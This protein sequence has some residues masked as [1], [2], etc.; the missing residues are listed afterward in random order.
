[1]IFLPENSHSRRIVDAVSWKIRRK[2]RVEQ[3]FSILLK[4]L[5]LLPNLANPG[6]AT[7]DSGWKFDWSRNCVPEDG[8][9][10]PIPDV[11][12]RGGAPF[13][14]ALGHGV[15]SVGATA[16]EAF[17]DPTGLDR[18]VVLP[19]SRMSIVAAAPLKRFGQR[20]SY[21]AKWSLEL[22][23]GDWQVTMDGPWGALAWMAHLGGWPEP[24]CPSKGKE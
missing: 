7:P 19:L 20:R 10:L 1:M 4:V 12:L 21:D 5:R 3:S 13:M 2:G 18:R 23:G 15:V 6:G 8:G 9:I 11:R 16:S 22:S 17:I 14:P 24:G